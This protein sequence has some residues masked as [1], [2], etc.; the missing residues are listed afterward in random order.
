[1][2]DIFFILKSIIV[3]KY[4]IQKKKKTIIIFN[5]SLIIYVHITF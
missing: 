2:L 3:I 1:M 5:E 4:N